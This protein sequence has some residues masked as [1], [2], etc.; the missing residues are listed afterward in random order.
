MS[1]M[2]SSSLLAI[3]AKKS[4]GVVIEARLK[5]SGKMDQHYLCPSIVYC[6]WHV[7]PPDSES[8]LVL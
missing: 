2:E 1:N 3:N 5:K 7:H 6:Q 8:L 4:E